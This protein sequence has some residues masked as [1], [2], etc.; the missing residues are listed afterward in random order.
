MFFIEFWVL[1][2]LIPS[3]DCFPQGLLIQVVTTNV[4]VCIL[5]RYNNKA[6]CDFRSF[7]KNCIK[8]SPD[9]FFEQNVF[10]SLLP[11]L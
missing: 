3:M 9:N 4:C 7:M 8:V 10:P 1:G 11:M 6:L 5:G 2:Q